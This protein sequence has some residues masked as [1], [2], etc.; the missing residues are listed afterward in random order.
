LPRPFTGAPAAAILLPSNQLT[1]R[2]LP[3]ATIVGWSTLPLKPAIFL[4]VF[5]PSVL[6]VTV[7]VQ[8]VDR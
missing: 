7:T 5:P 1:H 6:I 2:L 4:K 8:L 3:S